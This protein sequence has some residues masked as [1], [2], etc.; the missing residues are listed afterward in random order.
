M[1][2]TLKILSMWNLLSPPFLPPYATITTYYEAP[3]ADRITSKQDFAASL[4]WMKAWQLKYIN[5][6]AFEQ[7]N[8]IFNPMTLL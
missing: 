1:S 6:V 3:H 5:V 4:P 2:N 7:E 8:L